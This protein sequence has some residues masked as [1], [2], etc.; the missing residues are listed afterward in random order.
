MRRIQI[1]VP[2]LNQMQSSFRGCS[3][4]LLLLVFRSEFKSEKPAAE[5]LKKNASPPI[6]EARGQTAASLDLPV[7]NRGGTEGHFGS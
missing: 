2:P 3:S 6:I 7:L 5:S 4:V 1:S